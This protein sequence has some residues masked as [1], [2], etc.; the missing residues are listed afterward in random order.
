MLI[1]NDVSDYINLL[2]RMAHIICN[3][4]LFLKLGNKL[5]F[6]VVRVTVKTTNEKR[7][8]IKERC[9]S[10]QNPMPCIK[11]R[12]RKAKIKKVLPSASMKR[13]HQILG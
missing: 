8:T 13:Q 11:R 5:G 2:V 9:R 7:N 6:K 12:S 3:H 4:F 10:T 1:I